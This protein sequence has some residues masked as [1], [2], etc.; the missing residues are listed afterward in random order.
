MKENID[1]LIR[2]GMR[3]NYNCVFCNVFN[4]EEIPDRSISELKRD[5]DAI[6]HDVRL[7]SISGGEPL[8]Y[9]DLGELIGHAKSKGWEVNLQTNASLVTREKAAA[10]KRAGLDSAF[11]N[12]PSHDAEVFSSLTATN[13]NVFE[14]A[15]KGIRMLIDE[16]VEVMLNLVVN[17][18]NYMELV[19]YLRFVHEKFPEVKDVNFS[20]IQPHGSARI[21]A[22]LVPDYRDV[23]P[24]LK[25]AMEVSSELGIRVVNP[26][27]GLPMC[28]VHDSMVMNDNSEYLSGTEVRNDG[29]I[30]RPLSR[31]VGSKMQPPSCSDCYLKNFCL[32]VWNAYYEIRGDVVEPPH[33]ALRIWPNG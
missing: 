12:L 1:E 33:R 2:M 30:P 6:S 7:L 14:Q 13:Q 15:L 16:G 19:P 5:V 18:T 9:P 24:F 28:M 17:E 31:V 22:H 27:C 3:C 10:L 11:I 20:V 23:K 26:F 25:K 8:L 21:N 32:G 4:N 29:G